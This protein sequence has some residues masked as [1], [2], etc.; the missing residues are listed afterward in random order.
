MTLF[1]FFG[2]MLVMAF[3]IG[4]AVWSFSSANDEQMAHCA[5]IPLED[6][7]ED[8]NIDG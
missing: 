2:D 8:E 7:D 1:I 4:V 5:R 3:M 6:E